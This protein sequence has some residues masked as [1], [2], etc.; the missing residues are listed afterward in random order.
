MWLSN[1][2]LEI[3]SYRNRYDGKKIDKNID[4][5]NENVGIKNEYGDECDEYDGYDGYDGINVIMKNEKKCNGLSLKEWI[6]VRSM[7]P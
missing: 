5:E 1:K 2:L 6:E 3:C 7:Y 4:I